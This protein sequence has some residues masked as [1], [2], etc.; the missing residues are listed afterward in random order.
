MVSKFLLTCTEFL[1]ALAFL[2]ILIT[3]EISLYDH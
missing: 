1:N 2:Q 3:K